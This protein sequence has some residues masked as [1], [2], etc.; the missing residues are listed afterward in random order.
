MTDKIETV[1]PTMAWQLIG[2]WRGLGGI[3][4]LFSVIVGALVVRE[5]SP[6]VVTIVF[7]AFGAGTAF[8]AALAFWARDRWLRQIGVI[9]ER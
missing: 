5:P 8:A 2:I 7:P 4:I 6:M 3:A 9:H 1:F